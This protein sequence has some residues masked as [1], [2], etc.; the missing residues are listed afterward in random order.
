MPGSTEKVGAHPAKP[1]DGADNCAAFDSKLGP[2][3]GPKLGAPA[4]VVKPTVAEASETS[5][6]SKKYKEL[7]KKEPLLNRDLTRKSMLRVQKKEV[8][9]MYKQHEASFWTAEEIDLHQDLKDWD[10]LN[11]DERHFI[12]YVLAF[13][14][15]SDGIVLENLA[16]KFIKEVQLPEARAFYGFQLAMENI[17]SETYSLLIET[18]IKD[19]QEKTELFQ[20]IHKIDAIAVKARWAVKWI[21]NESSF[22]ERLVAFAAVE[23]ILFSGSFCAIFWMKKRGKMPG[24]CFSNELISRDEGLH[25]DFACLLYSM[26]HN[27]LPVKVVQDMIAGAVEVEKE[28]IC[29]SLPCKLIGMNSDSMIDYIQFVADKLLIQLGA[30]K[31]YNSENPFEFMEL[32]SVRGKTNFFEKRVGEYQKAGVMSTK[33]DQMFDT[34]ADF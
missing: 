24:L 18:Y 32:I 25:A 19:P 10:A 29:E 30:P 34:N 11:P 2:K 17:H 26:L 13:F 28:F 15:A 20:A 23:G 12:K 3:L 6:L 21:N 1:S 33:E 4:A 27:P 7:E 31:I 16:S 5:L 14:A 22:A 8:W 9:A